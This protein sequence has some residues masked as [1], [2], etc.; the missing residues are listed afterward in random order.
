MVFLQHK[1]LLG[2]QRKGLARAECSVLLA[3]CADPG[4][5]GTQ[6]WTASNGGMPLALCRWDWEVGLAWPLPS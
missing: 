3:V 5:V 6:V 4:H 1:G 2:G